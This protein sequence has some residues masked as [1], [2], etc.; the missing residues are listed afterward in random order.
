MPEELTTKDHFQQLYAGV[1]P[2]DIGKPQPALL[3]VADSI[4]GNVLDAGC[5]TGENALYFAE[6]GQPV[7]GIDFLEQPIAEARRKSQQRN[8][9]ATFLV[10]DALALTGLDEQF[11]SAIDC[12]LFH[13]FS[14]DDRGRYIEN[15]AQLVKPNGRL[16]LLCFSDNE[17]PGEGPRRVT[18]QEIEVTFAKGWKVESIQDTQFEIQPEFGELFSPGGPFAWLCVIRKV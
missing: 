16:F 9:A 12:G 2:W 10:R 3:A 4:T 5:G 11:D 8:V 18:Q 15:L 13:T 6:R 17:P 1:A 14:D 7:T